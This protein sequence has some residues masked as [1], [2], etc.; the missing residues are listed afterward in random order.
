MVN[1]CVESI[2][3]S[4]FNSTIWDCS[5]SV[6]TAASKGQG[7]DFLVTIFCCKWYILQ[8]QVQDV[9][10]QE[11]AAAFELKPSILR[12]SCGIFMSVWEK[13]NGRCYCSALK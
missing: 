9:K 7:G 6:A 4:F 2:H 8:L 12:P 3:R 1:M 13:E 10:S 11:P 5:A